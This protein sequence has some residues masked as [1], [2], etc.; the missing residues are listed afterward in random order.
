VDRIK[1][2][3]VCYAEENAEH[4]KRV[5]LFTI[6]N[7]I[8][9]DVEARLKKVAAIGYKITAFLLAEVPADNIKMDFDLAWVIKA[10]KDQVE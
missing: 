3:K 9:S 6:F 2:R 1:L 5:Q 10:G 4:A 8:I 7:I